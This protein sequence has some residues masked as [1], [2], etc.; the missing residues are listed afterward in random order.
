MTVK[1][2][3]CYGGERLTKKGRERI[4]RDGELIVNPELAKSILPTESGF[5]FGNTEYDDNY[6][7]DLRYTSNLIGAILDKVT[8]ASDG[9]GHVVK[10]GSPWML[11]FYYQASW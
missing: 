1:S 5:F 4:N 11:D 9:W 3:K 10:G 2:D 8:E 7:Y 6:L